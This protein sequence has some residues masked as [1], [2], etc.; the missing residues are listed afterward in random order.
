MSAIE[1]F[2]PIWAAL[3][4]L[5]AMSGKLAEAKA[6]GQLTGFVSLAQWLPSLARQ[7]AQR[8]ALEGELLECHA[9]ALLAAGA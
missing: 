1:K 2:L 5:E 6:N 7:Q 8:T 3:Q 4:R 9:I